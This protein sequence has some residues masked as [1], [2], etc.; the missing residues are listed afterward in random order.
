MHS[1]KKQFSRR[2]D[3]SPVSER[4]S[5]SDANAANAAAPE[6]T[7]DNNSHSVIGDVQPQQSAS[8]TASV[9]ASVENDAKRKADLLQ[10]SV[11]ELAKRSV[12]LLR[13]ANDDGANDSKHVQALVNAVSALDDLKDSVLSHACRTT[14][15]W[16][17][18]SATHA[19]RARLAAMAVIAQTAK[20]VASH[21]AAAGD[22]ERALQ[23]AIALAQAGGTCILVT[24]WQA[25]RAAG[26]G[27]F[28]ELVR[29][30]VRD[31][32]HAGEACAK[33]RN[34]ELLLCGP[35]DEPL[36]A[37]LR[38]GG[39]A[40]RVF[41]RR[42][43]AIVERERAAGVG[44]GLLG[45]VPLFV[46]AACRYLL[47]DESVR[48]Q[49]LFRIS[50]D[51][52]DIRAYKDA[53]DHGLRPRCAHAGGV[54]VVAGTLKLWLRELAEPLLTFA[55][56]ASFVDAARID[57]EP[58]RAA[59]LRELVRA[60]P[61]V[62]L[63]TLR[64]VLC[65]AAQVSLHEAENMMNARNLS[66][67]LGPNLLRAERENEMTMIDDMETATAVAVTMIRCY[68]TV[69]AG[70]LAAERARALTPV[71]GDDD[72]PIDRVLAA[73]VSIYALDSPGAAAAPAH[74][75]LVGRHAGACGAVADLA[76]H[77]V[78]RLHCSAA[79]TA[80]TAAAAA[81]EAA[82]RKA[83]VA[84]PAQLRMRPRAPPQIAPR[85][86]L[87]VARTPLA[88]QLLAR[89]LDGAWLADDAAPVDA[90]RA[91]LALY[92]RR[93]FDTAQ[94][95]DQAGAAPHL[96]N[97]WLDWAALFDAPQQ[98]DAAWQKLE[99]RICAEISL[100]I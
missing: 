45:D 76:A 87:A 97:Y 31:E 82:L 77:R 53:L 34:R 79:A 35:R 100:T 50:G 2:T 29:I 55:A 23:R 95:L 6:S 9:W 81:Y 33:L 44:G 49:G 72:E 92:S 40:L 63:A 16:R 65:V 36:L 5:S 69:F 70:S 27:A 56:R 12:R 14:L 85:T 30:A 60:L 83:G 18:A 89:H 25:E 15:A 1:L 48:T 7:N 99:H 71:A 80:I 17:A 91:A 47:R 22:D 28:E 67:V 84:E 73:G 51:Q 90:R 39:H 41:G 86:A 64:R 32:K 93:A 98:D 52:Y 74:A 68:E 37:A 96:D 10:K 8:V 20:D 38:A 57:D 78:L 3:G 54:H 58:A 88:R 21:V 46:H 43:D 62:Y 26:A 66:I 94:L 13:A 59:R 19:A 11:E 42:V 75:P 4:E 61:P 24:L